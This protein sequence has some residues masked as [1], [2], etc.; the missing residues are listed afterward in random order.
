MSKLTVVKSTFFKKSTAQSFTLTAKEKVIV[1]VG[2]TFEYNSDSLSVV[3][4]H[5]RVELDEEIAPFGQVG[6][7]YTPT[8]HLEE[9]DFS[10]RIVRLLLSDEYWAILR[11][12]EYLRRGVDNTCVAFAST[13]LRRLG[14]DVPTNPVE[15]SLVTTPFK[16]WLEEQ[17]GLVLD[18]IDN[19]NHL[20]PGDLCFSKDDPNW[21]GYPAHVY[22]FIRYYP[23]D[24]GKSY[25]VDNQ[26]TEHVRNLDSGSPYKTPFAFAFR[27]FGFDVRSQPRRAM[28]KTAFIDASKPLREKLQNNEA[29]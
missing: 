8:V 13:A 2:E 29:F 18:R 17:E 11:D 22:F 10:N 16:E 21:P 24:D 5:Y 1:N 26:G 3:G 28:L 14:I 9:S 27:L 6:Y 19:L 23:G 15:I 25:V 4:E 20:Q 12:A 7:F